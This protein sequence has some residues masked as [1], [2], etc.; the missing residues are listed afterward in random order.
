MTFSD[1]LSAVSRARRDEIPKTDWLV[2]IQNNPCSIQPSNRI[3]HV[4]RYC[5][6]ISSAQSHCIHYVLAHDTNCMGT[7]RDEHIR[8]NDFIKTY[9]RYKPS[10]Q[11][12]FDFFSYTV[13]SVDKLK[14]KSK[15]FESNIFLGTP[16]FV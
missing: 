7:T 9:W 12:K 11:I 6:D 1:E 4:Y 13:D 16:M 5:C 10:S 14:S 3:L 8:A 2:V 15:H